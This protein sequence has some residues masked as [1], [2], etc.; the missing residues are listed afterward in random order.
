VPPGALLATAA[1]RAA[2]RALHRISPPDIPDATAVRLALGCRADGDWVALF[3]P[4]G[5]LP[6]TSPALR[7]ALERHLPG[8]L[9]RA[10]ARAR[11]AA[12]G[13][14][15][16]YG[17]TLD[18]RRGVGPGSAWDWQRDPTHGGRF[19]G[20]APS[21][22]LPPA[23][24]QDPKMAWALA[25]G[26]AW[27]ALACGAALDAGDGAALAAA[28]SAS[29]TDFVGENPVGRGI[30]WASA[31]EAGLR[32]WNLLV[33]LRVLSVRAPP[34][35]PL[36]RAAAQLLAATGRF[37]LAHLEDDT[38]VPN[39]HLVADLLGLLACAA[40][41]PGWPEAGRW[42]GIAMA[43]LRRAA[44][45]QVLPDGLS[46]EGSVAYHRFA[47]E[48]FTAGLLVAH[49][50]RRGLGGA[51]TRTL[52]AMF[53]ATRTLLTSSGELP[54]LGD[55][56]SGHAFAL[57]QRGPTEGGYLLPLGAALLHEPA[58]LLAQA[59]PSGDVAAAEAAE[60]LW[61]LGPAAL[62]FLA[63]ARPGPPT[64]SAVLPAG[65]FHVL[66][67]GPFE[68]FFSCG[69]S[70]QRGIGGHSHNDKL[71]IELWVAGA[72]A[73]CD[74]GMPVYGRDPALRDRFRSTSAHAT[75]AVDGLE[76]V[77]LVPGRIF[78]LPDAA[79]ARL[80]GFS[81]GVDA[82]HLTG[83]HRGYAGR[84]GVV[85]RRVLRAHE[86]GLVV[87]DRL[88]GVGLHAV[89]LRW[90]LAAAAGV[91]VR[92][93]TP[94]ERQAIRALAQHTALHCPMAE[95]QAVAVPLTGGARLVL[96]FSAVGLTPQLVPALR[97]PGYDEVREGCAVA[98]EGRLELPAT[99]AT[100]FLHVR[101][102]GG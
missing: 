32:A 17:R 11:D 20:R 46:F 55:N 83:S 41:L 2:R 44:A 16:V 72:L 30:H 10:L 79:D 25:R 15:H 40:G 56:D 67:R 47:L 50:S 38:A 28:L 60:A 5:A 9:P 94:A 92:P 82:D 66:R 64:G 91:E 52:R 7:E 80:E 43:G 75:V 86:D 45:E 1:R 95:A 62:R 73:V 22:A 87:V 57:R 29:V 3:S 65:G 37:V 42:R 23:P 27:V 101:R 81:R 93:L 48:L 71:G 77:E 70:G 36:A 63:R 68:A 100:V 21:A 58:L 78:A 59:W 84:V 13:R 61:L 98:L 24:G 39:N 96:A 8:E 14:I 69:P 31:M 4:G 90:P 97:S 74:P 53:R 18:V 6:W 102:D 76:Q 54:Q 89:A 99:I 19:E 51:Y 88:E 33:A 35:P 85:H 26:E 12:A 34:D 49:H